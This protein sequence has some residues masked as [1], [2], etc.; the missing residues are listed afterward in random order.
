M[1]TP[2]META[3][4]VVAK[5]TGF[6]VFFGN[7][8]QFLNENATA[9]GLLIALASA[10]VQWYYTRERNKREERELELKGRNE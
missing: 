4:G 8:L 3:S 2:S 10:G 7:A 5:V 1:A 9:L 6:G